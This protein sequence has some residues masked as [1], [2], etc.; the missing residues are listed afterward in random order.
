MSWSFQVERCDGSA[1]IR[2]FGV[3]DVRDALTLGDPLTA[4]RKSGERFE[5]REVGEMS[6]GDGLGQGQ[7]RKHV[8]F[9][10]A[11]AETQP[12]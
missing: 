12:R 2:A 5:R 3:V 8:A 4:M 11:P 7:C 6:S 1:D 10:I 9:V